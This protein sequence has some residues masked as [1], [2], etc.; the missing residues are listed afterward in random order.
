MVNAY[1]DNIA[2]CVDCRYCWTHNRCAI[3]D[4][5][6]EIYRLLSEVDNV[7]IASPIYFSQLTGP[8]LSVASRLQYLYVSRMM[9]NDIVELNPKKGAILLSGGGDGSA[10]PAI[11]MASILLRQ[12]GAEVVGAECSLG[13]NTIPASEDGQ[14]LAAVVALAEDM[15]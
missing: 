5:M 13:T 15:K 3:D 9:R 14:A 2:P 7:V 12:M 1:C 6:G 4:G 11:K 8:L 10:E